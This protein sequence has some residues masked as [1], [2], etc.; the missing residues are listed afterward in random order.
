MGNVG[1]IPRF[2]P[3]GE[4]G[5][6]AGVSASLCYSSVTGRALQTTAVHSVLFQYYLAISLR[7]S[8]SYLHLVGTA[9]C[10][11]ER[12]GAKRNVGAGQVCDGAP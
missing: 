6:Q 2:I 5:L 9:I 10:L 3:R 4:E 8:K 1:V 7:H 12:G 11:A